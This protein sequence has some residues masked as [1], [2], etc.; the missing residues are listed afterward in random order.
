MFGDNM[1]FM[2]TDTDSL[3]IWVKHPNLKQYM[4]LPENNE[5]FEIGD[6][7]R[8][9]PGKFKLEKENIIEFKAFCSKN[10]YYIMKVG[11]KYVYNMKF[12]GIPEKCR[13]GKELTQEEIIKHLESNSTLQQPS[14]YRY[15]H[16]RSKKH[17][18]YVE[19]VIKVVSSED[20]KR[21]WI[22][23]IHTLALGD[24]RIINI[25]K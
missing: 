10:Y 23:D 11:D 5:I 22:D 18:I 21:Y 19:D 13:S 24:Y 8:R 4:M 15:K 3:V 2:Y 6:H 1:K 12:K 17:E 7:N 16:L 14:E 20:D 25:P 9:I